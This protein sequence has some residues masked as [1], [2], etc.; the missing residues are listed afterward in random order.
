MS[1]IHIS[2]WLLSLCTLAFCYI[3]VLPYFTSPLRSIPGPFLTKFSNLWRLLAT[4]GGRPEL[5]HRRLHEQYGPVV[6]LG[7]NCVSLSD[8]S[9]V[10][11]IYNAKGDFIKVSI[12]CIILRARLLWNEANFAWLQSQFYSVNDVMVGRATVATI[13]GTRS[14]AH[15]ASQQR[16]VHKCYRLPNIKEFES[17]VDHIIE[18]FQTRLAEECIHSTGSGLC[19]M[20][21][22]INYCRLIL[23]I[24]V[25]GKLTTSKM[26]GMSTVKYPFRSLSDSWTPGM[27]SM[28][29]SGQV[30]E[31]LTTLQ[32]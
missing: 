21:E 2:I 5:E 4:Y 29:C 13:F 3:F 1:S 16:L 11:T 23:L 22:W 20:D 26:L 14:N 6:R 10:K 27:I 18:K 25:V 15:H 9:L 32:L 30:K 19:K 28:V 7:P 12:I 31:P 17:H 24:V 8:P